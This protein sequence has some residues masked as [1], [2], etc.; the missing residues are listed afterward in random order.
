MLSL[1]YE[2]PMLALLV[3]VFLIFSIILHEL[4]HGAVAY[5][6]GDDTARING[7][8]TLNPIAHFDLIGFFM[9]V[10]VGFGYAKPVPVN[11]TNFKNHKKGSFLVSI[12]GVTVNLILSFLFLGL[13][14]LLITMVTKLPAE[15]FA[16]YLSEYFALAFYY[17]SL[18]NLTLCFFNLLPLYPLDGFRLIESLTKYMNPIV[19]FLRNYGSMILL[20]LFGVHLIA[21]V[22]N[23]P[24]FL[25]PLSLYFRYTAELVFNGFFKIFLWIFV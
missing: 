21:D 5:A 17:T 16:A 22:F 3:A 18:C 4:A 10:T 11:P 25:D 9:L 13:Y 24:I 8:L 12:A 7:R 19:R 15:G 14:F 6:C 20:A 2:N 1:F 23:L